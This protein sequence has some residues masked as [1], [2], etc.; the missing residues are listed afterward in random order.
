MA[1]GSTTTLGLDLG[2]TGARCVELVWE[3]ERPKLQQWAAADF[4]AE[5]TDWRM[6]N[7]EDVSDVIRGLVEQRKLR[8][9]WVAHSVSGEAVA[10]QYFNFPQIMPE[11]VAEAVRIEVE[12]ALPFRVEEALVSYILFPDQRATQGKVRTHGLAIAADGDLVESRLGAIRRANL[13]PFCVETDATACANAFLITRK[14]SDAGTTAILNIGHRYSNLALLGGEGTLL[15]RDVPWA[16]SQLTQA[17]AALLSVTVPEAEDMKRRH[18]EQGPAAAGTLGDRVPEVLQSA[19]K[20]FVGRLRDTIDYWV[21]E[22]LVPGLGHMFITGGGSQVRGL[23]EFLSASLSVPVER[24]SPLLDIT[25]DKTGELKP[26]AY[27]LSVAF[28]LA[29]RK[30]E[31]KK[32]RVSA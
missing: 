28:G 23:P 1:W 15:V 32:K 7:W 21:G 19:S 24:W 5:V 12:T 11:D 26:W 6:T 9:R 27:R 29:L 8:A 13:E 22:R 30:F 18:W 3:N 20:E 4:P 17:I 10:P 14:L 25:E 31:R 2:A 16:G